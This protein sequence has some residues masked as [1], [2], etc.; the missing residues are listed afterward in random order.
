M[1]K[2]S[3]SKLRSKGFK[4]KNVVQICV[5][6]VICLWY[7][8]QIRH[9]NNE[10]KAE[11]VVNSSEKELGGLKLGRKDLH[12]QPD[13]EKDGP[14][15]KASEDPVEIKAVEGQG[16][17]D[18]EIDGHDQDDD[19]SEDLIDEDD[20][21]REDGSSSD[22]I[23]NEEMDNQVDDESSSSSKTD[24]EGNGSDNALGAVMQD[25]HTQPLFTL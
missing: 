21:D 13:F 7:I 10:K 25:D 6:V 5:L 4:V 19:D 14:K 1:W 20:I 9:A 3:P 15:E 2:Q 17:G 24:E 11:D 8:H 12:V 18:D 16:V 22:D 23:D